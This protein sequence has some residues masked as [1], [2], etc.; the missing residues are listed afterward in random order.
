VY[1]K[2]L[3]VREPVVWIDEKP[4]VL[5]EEVRPPPAMQPGRVARRDTYRSHG[6]RFL[7]RPAQGG[8]A[9]HQG[10]AQPFL[11]RVCRL[12]VGRCCGLPGSRY[13]PSGYG[14]PEFAY[15]QG[16]GRPIRHRGGQLAVES[17]HGALHPKT[18]QLVEPGGRLPVLYSPGNAWA[19]AGWGMTIWKES[20]A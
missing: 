20:R 13:H 17:V 15:R 16:P 18:R 10:D 8:A 6:Q 14:Q 4:V 3:S 11:P 2:P 5:Q 9:F 1:E 7:R 19:D 12:P